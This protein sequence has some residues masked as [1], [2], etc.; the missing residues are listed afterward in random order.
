MDMAMPKMAGMKKA[1]PEPKPKL[2]IRATMDRYGDI[3]SDL[4]YHKTAMKRCQDEI[5]CLEHEIKHFD[6]EKVAAQAL[7]SLKSE[8][9]MKKADMMR[10]ESMMDDDD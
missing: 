9:A 6:S 3:G 7:K 1:E 8:L 5:K 2:R 4:S 10:H